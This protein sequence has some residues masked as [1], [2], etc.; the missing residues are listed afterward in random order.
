MDTFDTSRIMRLVGEVATV[1]VIVGALNWLLVG[2]LNFNL[3]QKTVGNKDDET[4]KTALE[5]TVYILVGL[6][7][8]YIVYSKYIKKYLQ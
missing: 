6:S 8:V 5:R 1:L 2:T 7:A 4:K 3:V